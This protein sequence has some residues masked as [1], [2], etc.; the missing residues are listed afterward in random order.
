MPRLLTIFTGAQNIHLIKDVGLLPFFL[1]REFGYQATIA[2]YRNGDYPYL[3]TEVKGLQL[4]F[5]KRIFKFSTLDT[6]LF[7]LLNFRKYDILQCYHFNMRSLVILFFFKCLKKITLSK[8]FTYLKLDAVDSIKE[9]QLDFVQKFLSLNIDLISVESKLL[10]KFI[11]NNNLLARKVEYI[12]NGFF[13][14]GIRESVDF[15]SKENLIITVGRI[16]TY[17][18]NNE[19]L[20]E[21]FREFAEFDS[22]WKLEIIGPIERCFQDNIK[23]YFEL[24][25]KLVNRVV[26][27][28]SITSRRIL[29]SKYKRAKIFVLTSRN[30]GFPLV[31]LE[32][33]KAGCTVISSAFSS[34]FDITDNGKFG[35]LFPVGDK[36]ALVNA[37]LQTVSNTEKLCADCSAIQ[38]FGYE[39]YSFRKISIDLNEL[40]QFRCRS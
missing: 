29:E 37:L 38:E 25:P 35:A 32:A 17:E 40:I 2:T 16:G 34:A 18:K 21:A 3:E 26:F 8:A 12:P 14:L 11:N 30:E 23:E 5:I 39:N 36:N 1:H 15:N 20:L 31:Y 22:E 4:V 24:N 9:M 19:I 6:F 28:N 7:L 10:Y 27:T 13:D 33:I